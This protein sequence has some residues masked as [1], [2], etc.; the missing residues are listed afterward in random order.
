MHG[1][2]SPA[3]RPGLRRACWALCLGADWLGDAGLTAAVG[4]LPSQDAEALQRRHLEEEKRS[5]LQRAGSAGS[6]Q[7]TEAPEQQ[8]GRGQEKQRHKIIV[9]EVRQL[10]PGG[11]ATSNSPLLLRAVAVGTGSLHQDGPLASL[12]VAEA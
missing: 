4:V 8:Q 9:E 1:S 12:L 5:L 6:A 10:C 11:G 7:A 3:V 2:K